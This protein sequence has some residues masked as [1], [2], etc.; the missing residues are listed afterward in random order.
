[1]NNFSEDR[2]KQVMEFLDLRAFEV[3]VI[4]TEL[5]RKI[6]GVPILSVASAHD[7]RIITNRTITGDKKNFKS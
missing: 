6:D 4:C 2:K 3:W 1:M 5:Y 7:E